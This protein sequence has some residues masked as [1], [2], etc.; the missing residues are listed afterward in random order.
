MEII[1]R[2]YKFKARS[3]NMLSES[4]LPLYNDTDHNVREKQHKKMTHH[5]FKFMWM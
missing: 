1:K 5:I 2:E 3:R 4:Q